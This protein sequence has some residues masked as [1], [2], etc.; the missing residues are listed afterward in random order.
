MNLWQSLRKV[1]FALSLVLVLFTTAACA[2]NSQAAA[3]VTEQPRLGG[4]VSQVER[5]TT[6][7]AQEYGDWLVQTGKGLVKDAYVRDD[8][9]GVVITPQVRPNEVKSLA[10]SIVQSFHTNFPDRDLTVMMYAPDKAL[11]LT[12]QYTDKTQEIEYNTPEG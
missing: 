4:T 3:P 11:V 6:R 10:R 7:S 5:G 2:G 1:V 12:A 8:K 9:A